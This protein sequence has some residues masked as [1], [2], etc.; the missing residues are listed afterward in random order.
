MSKSRRLTGLC[1]EVLK[2][3]LIRN[4]FCWIRFQF[5][6]GDIRIFE[7]IGSEV[8]KETIEHNMGA[9]SNRAAYG[10]G[11]RMA[12]LLYPLA[13]LVRDIERPKVLIV[14]PR[15]EDDIFWA[16]SLGMLDARGLDLFSYSSMIDIGDMHATRYATAEFDAVILGWV[17]S[18]SSVPGG[19]LQECQR[20]VKPGG[21]L[22]FGIESNPELRAT[23]EV[24]PPRA[25][26]LNSASDIAALTTA[27][28]VFI[29]DPQL[30]IPTDN[31]VILKLSD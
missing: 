28:I 13:A 30:E 8:G 15:T 1:Y 29:H 24:K 5:K 12:L 6:K 27:N 2:I 20:I 9:L 26:S 18:Y 14:G 31:A 4:Y 23:G 19:L 3:D 11:N 17:V 16:R 10:M 21:Y 22:G 25:N 7:A